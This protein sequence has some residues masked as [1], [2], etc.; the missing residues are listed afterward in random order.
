MSKRSRFSRWLAVTLAIATAA[1]GLVAFESQSSEALAGAQFDPGNIISDGYF[2]NGNAMTQAQIQSFFD[3]HIGACANANCLNVLHVN[4]T[5]K[6]AK[7][8]DAGVL[9][10]NAYAGAANESAAA[11]IFKVQQACGISAKVIIVTLQKEQGL[12]TKNS[13]SDGILERAMGYGCPD[14]T[15]GTCA[16][17]YYGFFNQVYSAS[18]QLRRY[19][20]PTPFGTYQPGL[21]TIAWS[22]NAS[23]GSGV[24]NIKNRATAALY[25]YTPYQPNAAALANLSGIGDG[26]SSY[27]NR[28]FWVYYNTWF[29]SST[30]PPGTPE[31]SFD[32]VVPTA[33]QIPISGWSVDTDAVTTPVTISVQIDSSWLVLTANKPGADLSAQY[34]GAGTNHYFS[35]AFPASV[36]VHT[37][38]LYPVN[39]GGAGVTSTL[40]CQTVTVPASPPPVGAV[41]DATAASGSITVSGWA[42]R[43]DALTSPASV[44]INF[45]SQWIGATGGLAN[46]V[47]ATQVSGAGPNQGFSATFAAA[48]G[49]QSFCVWASPTSGPATQLGCRSL[50]VPAPTPSV[51]AIGSVTAATGGIAVSGWAVWPDAPST[52]V[53]VAV[54]IGA[55]WYG[56][57]AN[58]ASSAAAA[59]VPG[60]GPNHGFA[61]TIPQPPGTYSACVW[62]TQ[63]NGTA[64]SIGCR[65]VSVAS[66]AATKATLDSVTVAP[67]SVSVSGWAV[68]PTALTASVPIAVNIGSNW[69]AFTA[70]KANAA[71]ATA[72]PGAG[73]NHGYTGSIP[74]APGTYPVCVWATAANGTSATQIGC[75][76][77]VVPSAY[78]VVGALSSTDGGVGG[79]HVDGWAVNPA[80]PTAPVAIAVN[81]GSAWTAIPSGV[82]NSAAPAGFSGAG[83]NQGFSALVAEPV[84]TYNVCV[85]ASG[86]AGAVNLGC[87]VTS[88]SAPPTVAGA[89]TTAT[90]GVGSVALSGWAVWPS[91]PTTTVPIAAN[92][93]SNWVALPTGLA[94]SVAT[95]FV[96][97]AGP[98]QGYSGTMSAPSGNQTVC[99]W[100]TA[101]TGVAAMLGCKTVKVG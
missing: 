63:P 1:F 48:P 3:S 61:G 51:S 92:I 90:P 64:S 21:R 33:G 27:G 69:Y 26:C 35:G 81:I 36:G 17:Q 76:N 23:C 100:A 46:S 97:G 2:F 56:F 94:S 71:A 85:W 68:W 83:P 5:T 38:C 10:C 96:A 39:A 95:V 88:V 75:Q 44:A 29:G 86:P 19:G 65:T 57:S 49:L 101:S 73:G 87:K 28:N 25:N 55:N 42:V 43:P 11:I 67:S 16:S 4:T 72:V 80:A 66:A 30:L 47:A 32:P 58:Q 60:A 22:P 6:P 12:A 74:I 79:V 15:G 14:S 7:Y 8:S 31:G 41:T 59:A 84:G 40:G 99:I 20:T 53:A 50:V 34:P 78:P 93:G 9:V 45:G 70:D 24:V 98:N 91:A 82:A 89:L 77:A 18:W 13:V 62:V 52:A 37:V 54:N